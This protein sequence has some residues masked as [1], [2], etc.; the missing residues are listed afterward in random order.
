VA[1]DSGGGGGAGIASFFD[2]FTEVM[3]DYPA[4]SFFDLFVAVRP[5]IP[6]ASVQIRESPTLYPAD[7][8]F[9]LFVEVDVPGGMDSLHLHGE[10]GPGQPLT[11]SDV[12][13]PV[14]ADS[15]FDIFVEVSTDGMVIRESP[16]FTI[17]LTGTFVPE[18]ATVVL[19]M[20]A[21]AV[22]ALR[23]YWR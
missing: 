5:P 3:G 23:W 4:D 6:A 20:M 21:A 16:L 22:V 8:F 13:I 18:P 1:Y 9:D 2:I 7:S 15:F 11:F 14:A 19:M 12:H 10:I 17:T